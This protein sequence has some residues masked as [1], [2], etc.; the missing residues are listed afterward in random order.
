MIPSLLITTSAPDLEKSIEEGGALSGRVNAAGGTNHLVDSLSKGLPIEHAH[1]ALRKGCGS[2]VPAATDTDVK[3]KK[4]KKSVDDALDDIEKS[5]KRYTV[6]KAG[7]KVRKPEKD[8]VQKKQERQQRKEA[9]LAKSD[10][11]KALVFII[12]PSK[13]KKDPLLAGGH[14]EEFHTDADKETVDFLTRTGSVNP[15]DPVHNPP[16]TPELNGFPLAVP[17]LYCSL[18]ASDL[19]KAEEKKSLMQKAF[20]W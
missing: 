1:T 20:N 9:G 13:D 12:D 4:A 17:M 18:S 11:E 7:A 15:D 6:P 8:A 14:G 19:L 16:A 10:V 2:L 5:F 3:K